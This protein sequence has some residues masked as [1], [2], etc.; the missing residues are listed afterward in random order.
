MTGRR[1]PW[2]RSL[3]VLILGLAV[4]GLMFM[5]DATDDY[6]GW[7]LVISAAD[8]LWL[9]GV[10]LRGHDD[11]SAST[12]MSLSARLTASILLGVA[13][14]VLSASALYAVFCIGVIAAVPGDWDSML[15]LLALIAL[16]LLTLAWGLG[17]WRV[18]K[19]RT[20]RVAV[21]SVLAPLTPVGLAAFG[22]SYV[23]VHRP[24][25]GGMI[26][27]G[28]LLWFAL[29]APL[30]VLGWAVLPWLEVLLSER[31]AQVRVSRPG[32]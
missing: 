15:A 30:V 14:G 18:S 25:R 31:E 7:P 11:G 3:L 29:A 10:D 9:W 1:R 8:L 20:P 17:T 32:R 4:F 13:G 2:L 26:L 6:S 28:M 12:R 16:V 23:A 22:L 24:A 27:E 21:R 19:T 5:A